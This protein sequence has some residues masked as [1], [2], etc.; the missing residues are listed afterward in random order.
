MSSVSAK[1]AVV[2]YMWTV[3]CFHLQKTVFFCTFLQQLSCSLLNEFSV[4]RKNTLEFWP[5]LFDTI[6]EN[7]KVNLVP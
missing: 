1:T 3:S 2:K 4:T 7:L 6:N 5:D